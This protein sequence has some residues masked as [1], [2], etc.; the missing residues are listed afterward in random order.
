M[1]TAAGWSAGIVLCGA[2]VLGGCGGGSGTN[3][4]EVDASV[5][6][7]N[8]QASESIDV[9]NSMTSVQVTNSGGAVSDLSR[10]GVSGC[11]TIDVITTGSGGAWTDEALNFTNPPCSFTGSRGYGT[12]GITGTIDLTRSDTAGLD[13]N[14]NVQNLEFMFTTQNATYSETRNGTRNVTASADL[15]TAISA[16]TVNFV[17]AEHSG[18]FTHA[19]TASFTPAS[20]LSLAAGQ[21]LPSGDFDFSGNSS[22]AGS[23]GN[24]DTFSVTTVTPLAYDSTCKDTAP[25]VFDSG[26][27]NLHGTKDSANAYASITWSNC[28][29]PTITYVKGS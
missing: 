10:G 23:N 17:G 13:F 28:Q 1:K 12:L 29:A 20:G 2:V 15:A 24:T 18:V 9:A 11:P 6:A 7:A 21:P 22:W 19:L 3:P 27:I 14:S 4:A 25:S 8:A 5:A 26:Q 16:M